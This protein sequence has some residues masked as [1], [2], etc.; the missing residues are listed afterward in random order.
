[1]KIRTKLAIVALALFLTLAGFNLIADAVVSTGVLAH[2]GHP[3]VTVEVTSVRVL[4]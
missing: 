2:G 4:A 3:S 1:M